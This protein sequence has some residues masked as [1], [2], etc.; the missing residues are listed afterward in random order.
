MS[1]PVIYVS[2]PLN[3][4][5][6]N[7]YQLYSVCQQSSRS[8]QNTSRDIRCFNIK[9]SNSKINEFPSPVIPVPPPLND[10]VINPTQMSSVCQQSSRY[11]QNTT[12]ESQA[13]AIPSQTSPDPSNT[14]LPPSTKN[15]SRNIYGCIVDVSKLKMSQQ[16]HHAVT[17]LHNYQDLCNK[18]YLQSMFV[19]TPTIPNI[20]SLSRSTLSSLDSGSFGRNRDDVN[21]Q[22]QNISEV[23]DTETLIAD[24]EELDPPQPKDISN[25]FAAEEFSY[26]SSSDPAKYKHAWIKAKVISTSILYDVKCSDAC[27]RALFIALNHK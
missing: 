12:P 9:Y 3:N 20:E 17:L 2:P 7:K 10:S 25:V 22:Q 14:M 15:G 27:S 5:V 1:L 21:I 18:N 13:S 26:C 8:S 6:I 16:Q 11:S 23:A 19:S 24:N 4:S